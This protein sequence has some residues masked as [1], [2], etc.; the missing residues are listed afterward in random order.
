M[1]A[2]T[3]QT[4]WSNRSQRKAL[5]HRI[6]GVLL[7]LA[8]WQL[9]AL[10]FPPLVVPPPRQVA[11]RLW[12]I[13]NSP[14][15][16]SVI[17][18]TLV[19]LLAGLA[20]GVTIGTLL[21]LLFGLCTKAEEIFYPFI[22]MLQSVPPVCWVVMALVWFGFNGKPCIFI[23]A[24]ASIPTMVINLSGGVEISTRSFFR[25]HNCTTSVTAKSLRHI[26]LPSVYP[27]FRMALEIII[28]SGWKLVVMGEVLTTSTGIGGAITTARLNIEPDAIIAWAV[29]LTAFCFLTEKILKTLLCRKGVTPC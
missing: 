28:G 6:I 7:L 22:S 1:T 25:W 2:C 9:A 29:L 20:I 10:F 19:R 8:L 15:F 18:T 11:L 13:I 23:V 21:G 12:E 5:L 16:P 17:F 24:T 26:I 4:K 27:C 14:G 3:M